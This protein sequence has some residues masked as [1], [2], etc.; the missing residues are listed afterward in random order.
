MQSCG[1]RRPSLCPSVNILRKSLILPDKWLD[2]DQTCTAWSPDWPASRMCAR[3][4]SKVTW[5]GHFYDFMK[6]TS[7]RRQMAGTLPNLHMMV[8]SLA[9]IQDVLKSR[10][11]WK[12]TWYGHFCDVTKCLLY[13]TVSR[14]VYMRS[15]YEAPLHSSSSIRQLDLMS[16]SWN[17]LLRH[18]RS[19]R[20]LPWWIYLPLSLTEQ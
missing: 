5:Y 16:K 9:C 19:S 8:P 12:V 2:H 6:I 11:G 1:I 7:S 13:N 10:S 20:V 18:W 4:R 3:S 17:E 15:L 14:S